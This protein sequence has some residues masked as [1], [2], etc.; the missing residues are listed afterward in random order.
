VWLQAQI[1]SDWFDRYGRRFSDYRLPK[2]KGNRLALAE[3]I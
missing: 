2:T 1:T 3:T